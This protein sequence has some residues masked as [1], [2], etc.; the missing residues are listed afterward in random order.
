MGTGVK[1]PAVKDTHGGERTEVGVYYLNAQTS[2]LSV[3][4]DI[5]YLE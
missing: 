5:R 4:H 3:C 2:C 1:H